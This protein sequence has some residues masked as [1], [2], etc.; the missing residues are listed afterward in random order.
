MARD[1][2]LL[3]NSSNNAGR[4][5]L[6]GSSLSTILLLL[7]LGTFCSGASMR[8]MDPLLPFLSS[9]FHVSLSE[10]GQTITYFSI[11]YGLSLFFIGAVGDRYGKLR[12]AT[13]ACV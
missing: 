2:T 13:W 1:K 9:E 7:S 8:I 12:V 6:G 5:G 3:R 11:T 10:A 4:D